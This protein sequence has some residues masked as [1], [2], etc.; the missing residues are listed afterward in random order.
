MIDLG[1]DPNLPFQGYKYR[2]ATIIK[3]PAGPVKIL[4]KHIYCFSN[5]F[6]NKY[7]V[8]IEQYDYDVY[9]IKFHLRKDTHNKKKYQVL[10]ATGDVGRVLATCIKILA[11]EILAKKS[12]A[13]F[14]FL[15][16]NSVG[17]A[18]NHTKRY[19]LYKRVVS[20][21]FSPE[22]FEHVY[23]ENKSAYALLNRNNKTPDLR[24]KVE[25]MFKSYYP[26]LE[27][28]ETLPPSATIG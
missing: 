15:G 21:Y 28:P 1:H 26:L 14:G 12:E 13:S 4:R 20:D 23:N 24:Q 11:D 25:S 22:S 6:N 18:K 8:I 27:E 2:L 7:I 9:I 19:N 16:M 17:E 3:E 5:R 10:T